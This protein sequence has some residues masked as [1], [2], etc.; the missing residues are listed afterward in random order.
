MTLRFKG[1]GNYK[2]LVIGNSFAANQAHLV[3][4][5][6]RNFS[7]ELTLFRMTA[8]EIMTTTDPSWCGA[9]RNYNYSAVLH[10]V[11]PDIVFVL[12]SVFANPRKPGEGVYGEVFATSYEGKPT[13]LKV[14]LIQT[15]H[16]S[17]RATISLA[18]QVR[19]RDQRYCRMR[20]ASKIGARAQR[21]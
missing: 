14:I 17:A 3:Y 21:T 2:I 20:R 7:S 9:T 13:A 18:A 11:E 16:R 8:C 15:K 1:T 4:D 19:L 6:F 10:T 5:A 12:L